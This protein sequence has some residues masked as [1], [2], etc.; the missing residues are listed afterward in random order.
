MRL[1]ILLLAAPLVA[2][3]LAPARG[4]LIVDFGST[5]SGGSPVAPGMT[6]GNVPNNPSSGAGPITYVDLSNI[7]TGGF[8]TAA[9]QGVVTMS[10]GDI[11]S[12]TFRAVNRGAPVAR[13]AAQNLGLNNETPNTP[14][15][16]PKS[17]A[18]NAKT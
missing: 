8:G 15:P 9:V 3:A 6:S 5:A 18:S 11:P 1:R 14:L 10:S 4:A 12:N 17:P 7:D 16:S 2:A 13:S